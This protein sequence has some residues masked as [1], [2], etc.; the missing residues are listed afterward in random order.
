MKFLYRLLASDA[1]SPKMKILF[2]L[3]FTVFVVGSVSIKNC[4]QI[5]FV[6]K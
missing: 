6:I 1:R 3:L 5:K 2:A 4:T